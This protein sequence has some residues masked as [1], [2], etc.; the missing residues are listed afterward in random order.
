MP[1]DREELVRVAVGAAARWR[2]E[3]QGWVTPVEEL[4]GLVVAAVDYLLDAGLVVPAGDMADAART[5]EGR[6]R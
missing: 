5:E 4:T 3:Q 6:S 1:P 2:A